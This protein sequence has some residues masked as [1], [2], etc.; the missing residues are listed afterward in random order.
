MLAP[1]WGSRVANGL[2]PQLWPLP[3]AGSHRVFPQEGVPVQVEAYQHTAALCKA[4]SPEDH[5]R[6]WTHDYECIMNTS[7]AQRQS[8]LQG[9]RLQCGIDP[10]PLV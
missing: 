2:I 7:S 6:V 3:R 8:Q 9:R 5:G 10:L 4:P 1:V